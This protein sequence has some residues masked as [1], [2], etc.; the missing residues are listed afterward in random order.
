MANIEDARKISSEFLKKTLN[1][2]DVRVI[3]AARGDDGWEAE[4]EA[5]EESSFIKAL[6]LPTRVMDRNVYTVRLD[7]HLEVQS[8]E[9]KGEEK[10]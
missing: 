2:E 6:G 5:Y 3:K 8:F 1:I 4:A 9:R 7:D 10:R